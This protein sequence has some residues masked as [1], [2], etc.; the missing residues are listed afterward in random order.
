MAEEVTEIPTSPGQGVAGGVDKEKFGSRTTFLS[1]QPIPIHQTL[2]LSA[3]A[4][5]AGLPWLS[6]V[7]YDAEDKVVIATFDA[8]GTGDAN[9]TITPIGVTAEVIEPGSTSVANVLVYR[10]GFFNKKALNWDPTYTA[11]V[12]DHAFEGASSPTQIFL[13]QNKYEMT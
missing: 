10:T 9:T 3:A 4:Q 7:G 1:P 5:A 8:V 11:A 12:R 6:V 13:G 2:P